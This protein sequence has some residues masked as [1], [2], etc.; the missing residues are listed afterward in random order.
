MKEPVLEEQRLVGGALGPLFQHPLEEEELQQ[1]V[2]GFLGAQA[3]D[4]PHQVVR[5]LIDPG[6]RAGI[7]M[8]GGRCSHGRPLRKEGETCGGSAHPALGR[9]FTRTPRGR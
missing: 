4:V 5:L 3:V 8:F 7:H 6:E 9:V 1:L 2:E